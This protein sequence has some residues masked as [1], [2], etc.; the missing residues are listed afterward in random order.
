MFGMKRYSLLSIGLALL[1][2]GRA[3]AQ[4]VFAR[5]GEVMQLL[6]ARCM[7]C[8]DQGK[9]RGG[10]NL[11]T[12]DGLLRGGDTGPAIVSG[13]AAKSLLYQLVTRTRSEEHTS[14]LQSQSNL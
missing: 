14:E 13:A 11:S 3:P 2:A 4:P 1:L 9:S 6:E 10:L 5:T 7:R 8:H 12:R